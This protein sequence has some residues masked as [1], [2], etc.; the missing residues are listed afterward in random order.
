MIVHRFMSLPEYNAL[1]SGKVLHNDTVHSQTG[2]KTDSVGFCFFTEDPDEAIQWLKGIVDA[3]VCVTL[4]I[5][6][7]LLN[8]SRGRYRDVEKDKG[9]GVFDNIPMRWRKEYCLT[10]YSLRDA[11]IVNVTAKYSIYKK[12]DLGQVVVEVDPSR[13]G[14]LIFK[15]GRV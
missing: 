11:R 9:S 8:E 10:E 12:T 14:G 5:P 7:E 6:M 15:I 3:D 13:P 2:Q 1:I 4:A